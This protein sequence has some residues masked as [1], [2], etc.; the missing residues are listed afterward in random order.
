M[1]K[2]EIKE[3]IRRVKTAIQVAL[4]DEEIGISI[5]AIWCFIFDSC[6]AIKYKCG[7][8]VMA[9]FI[10]IHEEKLTLLKKTL[11]EKDGDV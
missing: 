10:S 8:S 6:I 4:Q 9:D 5:G 1:T 3:E 2:T 7:D 11:L